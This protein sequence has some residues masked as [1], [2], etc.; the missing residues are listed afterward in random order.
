MLN[1][2]VERIL[3]SQEEISERCKQL[4]ESI[5]KDYEG[6]EPLMVSVLSGSFMFVSDLMRKVTI[7]A[8][9]SFLFASS[10]GSGTESSG[11]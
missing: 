10:Y 7:P 8:E 5:S 4:G 6:K 9:I 3:I 2:D 1:Q 11:K